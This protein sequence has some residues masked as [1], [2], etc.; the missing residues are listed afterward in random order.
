MLLLAMLRVACRSRGA[1]MVENLLLRQRLTVALRARP[2][3]PL[4]WRDRLF[5]LATRRLG[6]DWRRHLVLVQPETVLRWPRR[7]WRHF[8]WWRTRRPTGRPR[9]PRA[10][11]ALIRRLSEENRLWGTERIRG[12]LRTLG[13][14]VG[15]GSTSTSRR[16][17]PAVVPA[18]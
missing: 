11:C 16:N 4:R 12:E 5:W 2:R 18:A 13:I 8:W 1:V 17:K 15:N 10:V 9:V 7:G 6:A 3:P 14:A